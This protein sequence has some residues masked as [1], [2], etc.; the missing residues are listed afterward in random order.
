[1][2]PVGATEVLRELLPIELTT[3]LPC[4]VL[5]P[6]SGRLGSPMYS[7]RYCG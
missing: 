6:Q 5:F 3:Y 2:T 1:M 7:R 4:Q